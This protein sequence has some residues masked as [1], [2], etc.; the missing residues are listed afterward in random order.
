MSGRRRAGSTLSST[1]LMD[2]Q[3]IQGSLFTATSTSFFKNL[4]NQCLNFSLVSEVD[5][6]IGLDYLRAC[7]WAIL[8]LT[9][10]RRKNTIKTLDCMSF[11]LSRTK[12][13]IYWLF[14]CYCSSQRS[15]WNRRLPTHT[16][17]PTTRNIP[18]ILVTPGLKQPKEVWSEEIEALQAV[19]LWGDRSKGQLAGYVV[20]SDGYA[21]TWLSGV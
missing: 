2:R 6:E 7:N 4:L 3:L 1:Q 16:S 10:I 17:I 20:P 18:L 19:S 14:V 5:K 13:Q 9:I 12:I 15:S 8:K 11:L 21:K